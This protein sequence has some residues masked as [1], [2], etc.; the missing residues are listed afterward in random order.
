MACDDFQA[1]QHVSKLAE[2]IHKVNHTCLFLP[3]VR[4]CVVRLTLLYIAF[5]FAVSL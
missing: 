4:L 1:A 3:K 5:L 2:D